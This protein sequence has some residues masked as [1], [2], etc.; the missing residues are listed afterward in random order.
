VGYQLASLNA[1]LPPD[2]SAPITRAFNGR[3]KRQFIHIDDVEIEICSNTNGKY[4]VRHNLYWWITSGQKNPDP[5][6]NCV[7][8]NLKNA[9]NR[10]PNIRWSGYR[11]RFE[12]IV[13]DEDDVEVESVLLPLSMFED[14][15]KNGLSGRIL[16]EIQNGEYKSKPD[17]QRSIKIY[18]WLYKNS[19]VS[20]LQ[21]A[22]QT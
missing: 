16:E 8:I 18:A 5:D 17:D 12:T 1:S 21:A 14:L 6:S 15:L 13:F 9:E 22:N 19:L 7:I 11:F 2:L 10:L 4:F 3:M 20:L